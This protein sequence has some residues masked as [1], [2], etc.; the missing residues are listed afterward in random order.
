[1]DLK[2]GLIGT[3]FVIL[4]KTLALPTYFYIYVR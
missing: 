2:P 1:M 4:D 3:S